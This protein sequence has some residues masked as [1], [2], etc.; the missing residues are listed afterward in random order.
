MDVGLGRRLEE[1]G[2][3]N[4]EEIPETFSVASLAELG[5]PWGNTEQRVG[6][7]QAKEVMAHVRARVEDLP[8][9]IG[10]VELP[11]SSHYVMFDL[12]GLPAEQDGPDTVYLWGMRVYPASGGDPE[13]PTFDLAEFHEDGDRKAWEAFLLRCGRVFEQYGDDIPFVHWADYEKAKIR[14][15][16]DRFGDRGGIAKRLL[17]RNLVDLLPVSKRSF[18]LPLP[19]Y[20][21]KVVERY[22]GYERTKVPGYKGDQSIARYMLAVATEDEDLREEI[23]NELCAY[24]HEDLEATWAVFEWLRAR[25]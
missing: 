19:S 1:R 24:N 8:I 3:N 11:V 17:E 6:L 18:A 21:L 12:E 16:I 22:V 25:A 10:T 13:E 20:S 15:Y 2:L 23:I 9:P 4:F 7:S 5:R 14:L